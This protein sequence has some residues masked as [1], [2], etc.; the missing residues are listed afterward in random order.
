M[1][2]R[3]GRTSRHSRV[4]GR[5]RLGPPALLGL[6]VPLAL[7]VG[8]GSARP[9]AAAGPALQATLVWSK[10]IPGGSFRASSPVPATLDGHGASVLVGSL[11]GDVY[12]F[13]LG[14]GGPVA[15]WP[16]RTGHEV[17]STPSVAPLSAGGSDDVFVGSGSYDAPGGDYLSY[18][19]S[20]NLRWRVAAKDPNQASAPVYPTMAVGDINGDGS[21]SATAGALGLD[22]YSM[23]ATT[24]A[25]NRGWPV[26]TNDTVFSSPSLASLSGVGPP[27]VVM[28]GD[29]SPGA[30]FKGHNA[31]P[32]QQGG[33]LYAINGT[34]N[35]L[36]YHYFDEVVTS[37]PAVGNLSGNGTPDIAVG[38]GF[39][40]HQR[41][42][43][44]VDS[45]KLF[46]FNSKGA[47]LWD[48]DLGGYTRPSP[49]LG[50][51]EGNG[52]LDVVEATSGTTSSGQRGQI[53]AFSGSGNV[54][55]GFPESTGGAVFGSPTTADLTGR[56]YDDVLVPT[57]AGLQIYDGRTG[58]R[59]ATLATQIGLQ[60]SALVTQDAPGV[61]GITIAG[62]RG[63]ASSK[64]TGE[65]LH[66]QIRTGSTV[67]GLSWPEFRHDPAATGTVPLGP[68]AVATRTSNG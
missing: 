24:G 3:T 51:L 58:A 47:L 27:D 1:G 11:N 4:T 12:A 23:N 55:A 52:H 10:T 62:S 53:W 17:D 20:G 28:G 56:G 8:G 39:Y 60:N 14:N 64:G 16:V 15:G 42:D 26:R 46:V 13:H 67:G 6:L 61:I 35:L 9:A 5:R 25:V 59:V 41:G 29:S 66:Y 22:A 30:P 34:G 32:V 21:L 18:G 57:G 19:P 40:W 2:R 48:R 36:W 38:T 50:D 44:T 37:S 33:I 68:P 54:L 43:A 49:A 7:V 65:I 45:T 63:V 31:R